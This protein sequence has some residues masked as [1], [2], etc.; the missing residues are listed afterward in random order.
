MKVH[1]DST[2]RDAVRPGIRGPIRPN[3]ARGPYDL[4]R[5]HVWKIFLP[6]LDFRPRVLIQGLQLRHGWQSPIGVG[7]ERQ[8]GAG[9][10]GRVPGSLPTIVPLL[11]HK[12]GI[13]VCHRAVPVVCKRVACGDS[14]LGALCAGLRRCEAGGSEC[15]E[16]KKKSHRQACCHEPKRGG[17]VYEFLRHQFCAVLVCHWPIS[18]SRSPSLLS[19]G[20]A[21]ELCGSF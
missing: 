5:L 11:P 10:S 8:T 16:R 18:L 4:V 7:P 12:S 2:V 20:F 9:V 19:A 6:H 13:N 3:G 14:L 21:A 17:C 1:D 15:D